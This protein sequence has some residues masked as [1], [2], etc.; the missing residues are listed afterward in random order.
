MKIDAFESDKPLMLIPYPNGGWVI[1]Q[2]EPAHTGIN[3]KNLGAYS[4]AE[5]MLQALDVALS[6]E[7]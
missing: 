3:A 2:P 1:E 4:S 6:G 5:D 7:E